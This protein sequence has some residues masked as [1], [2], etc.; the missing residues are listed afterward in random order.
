MALQVAEQNHSAKQLVLIGI[1]TNGCVIAEKISGY[2]K[3][4]FK[5][6]VVV[7]E[8]GMDKKNPGEIKLNKKMDF[9]GKTIVLIDDVANNYLKRYRPLPWL[10]AP[11]RPSRLMW[12]IQAYPFLQQQMNIFM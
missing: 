3:E 2:L 1:K 6:D 12:I 4:I 7:L 9:N 11:I 5:G 10:N 8:L